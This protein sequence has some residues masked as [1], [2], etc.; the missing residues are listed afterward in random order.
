MKN[1]KGIALVEVLVSVAL[2]G[3]VAAAV[4]NALSTATIANSDMNM[5]QKAWNLAE[6]QMEYVKSQGYAPSYT[7]TPVPG[8]SDYT[9]AIGA[10]PVPS[11]DEYI[12][13]VSVTITHTG[14]TLVTLEG[15]KLMR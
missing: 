9:V 4:Y 14:K 2:L 12:Q 10:T 3:V 11:R 1:E 13:G 7:P 15:Y 5:R 6:M 8:F